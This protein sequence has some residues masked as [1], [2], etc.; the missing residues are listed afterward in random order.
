MNH[1]SKEKAKIS[2][3]RYWHSDMTYRD[4]KKLAISTGCPFPEII[5]GDFYRLV[6]Y[7]DSNR[8]KKPNP[9]LIPQFDDWLE[10][11]LRERGCDY[12]VKPSLRLSYVSDEK[13]K[14]LENKPK[15]VKEKVKKEPT[16]RD[17]NNLLKGTKKSYTFELAK[18][19]FSFERV[20]RRVLKKFPDAS[21]KSLKIWYKKAMG[22]KR[23]LKEKVIK[24]KNVTPKKIKTPEQIA[25][26]K[27]ARF[28]KNTERR[29][30][31]E[32]A[33][34]RTQEFRDKTKKKKKKKKS[35]G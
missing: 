23:E 28:L 31:R 4:I 33:N 1:M 25:E 19:G 34:Q 30:R 17:E 3:Q 6:G 8:A 29:E 11:I 20:K 5:N 22:I 2:T 26:M 9:E 15:V 12:L 32:K 27:K 35:N 7:I 14:E 10:N 18:K 16:E 13:R 24:P 21:E